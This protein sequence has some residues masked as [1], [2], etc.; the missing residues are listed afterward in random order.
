MKNN[1]LFL[2]PIL[3]FAMVIFIG[4]EFFQP[5]LGPHGGTM[6]QVE[7]YNIEMKNT[8]GN[9]YTYLLDNKQN[10]IGNKGISCGVKFFYADNTNVEVLLK[11]LGEDCFFTETT[12]PFQTCR[13]T[14]NVFGK[15]VSARFENEVPM[16]KKK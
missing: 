1:M 6:K 5:T 2:M 15:K 14:F 13:I 10:P 16:V 9:F 12:T 4:S 3:L 7:N 8:Y 11:P